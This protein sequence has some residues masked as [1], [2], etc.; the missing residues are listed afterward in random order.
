MKEWVWLVGYVFVLVLNYAWYVFSSNLWNIWYRLYPVANRQSL[1]RLGEPLARGRLKY[2]ASKGKEGRPDSRTVNE[3]GREKVM[4]NRGRGMITN[5]PYVHTQNYFG[6]FSTCWLNIKLMQ[7]QNNTDF[8]G[9]HMT[10]SS[11]QPKK[12]P[13]IRH[14]SCL[15][16][17][18]LPIFCLKTGVPFY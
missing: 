17:V 18:R 7:D 3:V 16:P 9:S 4:N 1:T 5:T 6:I 12:I 11:K 2:G 13:K 15:E 10:L 8:I 14:L